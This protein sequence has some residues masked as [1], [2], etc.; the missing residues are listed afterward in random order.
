MGIISS[1][2]S[3]IKLGKILIG[4]GPDPSNDEDIDEELAD[5]EEE[6]LNTSIDESD[7]PEKEISGGRGVPDIQEYHKN[8]IAPFGLNER[9]EDPSRVRVGDDEVRT[10]F[11]NGWKDRPLNGFLENVFHGT[12]VMNDISIHIS[13]YDKRTAE[14]E[15][16]EKYNQAKKYVEQGDGD[17]TIINRA[18]RQYDLKQTQQT[19]EAVQAG[20]NLFDVGVYITIRGETEK[21]LDNAT[22]TIMSELRVTPAST[23]PEVPAKRQLE[24]FQSVNPIG[25]DKLGFT[26][27]MTGGAIGAMYPFSST[28]FIEKNGIDF[29]IHAGN[30]SPIIVSR[31]E[32]RGT[33]Y[34]QLTFGKIGAGKS[35]GSQ[36]ELLRTY[37]VRDDVELVMVDPMDGFDNVNMA[38][39]GDEI[40][41]GG[42]LG[43]NPL[44][45]QA[46]PEGV[47]DQIDPY[48]MTKTKVMEFFDMYFNLA[49]EDLS[50]IDNGRGV[51]ERAIDEAYK[52]NGILPNDPDTH[53]NPSPTI[54]DVENILKQ[55]AE[56]PSQFSDFESDTGIHE[57]HLEE[58][59]S[60]LQIHFSR[61]DEEGGEYSNLAKES[62]V[63]FS[64][65]D[66]HYIN[67]KSRE[68]S[69]K[70]GLMMHL[71]LSEVYEMAKRTDKKVMLYIDEAH[72]LMKDARSVEYLEQIV[73]HSRHSDL[74]I[75]FI[76]QT[77]EEF[78]END[79]AAKIAQMCSIVKI[80]R[81]ETTLPPEVSDALKL[82]PEEEQFIK[83]AS[84]G[85][86]ESSG[87]DASEALVGI[88]DKGYVP[89]LVVA[90][91]FEEAVIGGD[92]DTS[93]VEDPDVI[94][95]ATRQEEA[96]GQP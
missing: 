6:A 2:R 27:E 35:F 79:A 58:A 87:S 69:G 84:A 10:I 46:R 52:Q 71:L 19:L 8:I 41:V 80:H 33:G 31:F 53:D 77:I 73:R 63:N 93:S 13:P 95:E 47:D 37:A 44:E 78:F 12:D 51:L 56:D 81:V 1:F 40:V 90:S 72:Y 20:A 21:E 38:L 11:I 65:N 64:D 60:N 92:Y 70:I 96:Q 16:Q 85:G 94:E 66:V 34:N 36:L 23:D 29:G 9:K 4:R 17:S 25:E 91:Q 48:T 3:A 28:S 68:S 45:I 50:K 18:D 88:E 74:S 15:L 55:I 42:K 39:D 5:N 24:A 62:E 67:L 76:T 30:E 61:F 49:G 7:E 54:H 83:N 57:E 82:R 22:D 43:L 59:A 89:C 32:E 75:N 26:S 86:S 14:E